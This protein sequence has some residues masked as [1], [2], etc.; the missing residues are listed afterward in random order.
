MKQVETYTELINEENLLSAWQ[1]VIC[2]KTCPG[3]DGIGIHDFDQDLS[4][5]IRRI[6]FELDYGLYHAKPVQMIQGKKEV[7]LVTIED[8]IVA[9]CLKLYLNRLSIQYSVKNSYA[10]QEGKSIYGAVDYLQEN[11]KQYPYLYQCD[12][13]DFFPSISRKLLARKLKNYILDEKIYGLVL[14]FID[15]DTYKD[16]KIHK[17]EGLLL[18]NPLSPVFSN[19]YLYELDCQFE[20]K[21]PVYVRYSDDIIFAKNRK[22]TENECKWI[23]ER[24]AS[25]KLKLNHEKTKLI[26]PGEK[27]SYLG[28]E[29]LEKEEQRS[30]IY[31]GLEDE[32][33]L[34]KR[35]V[36]TEKSGNKIW[37][38]KFEGVID[39][40]SDYKIREELQQILCSYHDE[41]QAEDRLVERLLHYGLYISLE[42]LLEQREGII[43]YSKSDESYQKLFLKKNYRIYQGSLDRNQLQEY[44]EIDQIDGEKIFELLMHGSTIAIN[45]VNCGKSD[46]FVLDIDMDKQLLLEYGEDYEA[47]QKLKYRIRAIAFTVQ[48]ILKE[49]GIHAYVEESGYKGYHVWTFFSE[50]IKIEE[51]W[52]A[53]V[54][55]FEKINIP[56]GCH[57]EKI[58][59][60]GEECI[61]LPLSRHLLTGKRA[62]FVTILGEIADQD[63][64]IRQIEQNFY[65]VLYQGVKGKEEIKYAELPVRNRRKAERHI[66][67]K[68]VEIVEEKC[69]LIK[70]LLKKV[71][72]TH[73][74]THFERNALLYVYGHMGE[75]GQNYL[76]RIMAETINYS[77]EITQGFI[78][79]IREFPVSCDKLGKRFP[80]IPCCKCRFDE[81]PLFYPS[82]VIHAYC[83]DSEHVTKPDYINKRERLE[84]VKEYV[85]PNRLEELKKLL[86]DLTDRRKKIEQDLDTCRREIE[87][88]LRTGD[89]ED[90]G[91]VEKSGLVMDDTGI[92]LRLL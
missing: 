87:V 56:S 49:R 12:I 66:E 48:N 32:E 50:A 37:K 69:S 63:E 1:E 10:Y 86:V 62:Q 57:I 76:H 83:V 27:F 73:Y 43:K 55:L 8:K 30:R 74:L 47:V 75:L 61:K 22:F 64:Y 41:S 38:E 9:N 26:V 19:L 92:Y 31:I 67:T 84:R 68:V 3:L 13:T 14:Q 11:R 6:L 25:H 23:D 15:L 18:G 17:T 51:F 28:N 21:F 45:P 33:D 53:M 89:K 81:F 77:E 16:G 42:E 34:E 46:L 35:E 91:L 71:R 72:T 7:G 59:Y 65:A 4:K 39:K 20:K 52:E 88:Y 5:N 79:K 40:I 29:F 82:P 44:T 80:Q 60:L 36:L 24:L 78:D 70:E 90:G 85:E 54:F 2:H 58:P